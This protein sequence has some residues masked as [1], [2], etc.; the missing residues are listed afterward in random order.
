MWKRFVLNCLCD[1]SKIL[2]AENCFRLY[3]PWNR[4]NVFLLRSSADMR[5]K[6]LWVLR[7]RQN[8]RCPCRVVNFIVCIDVDR[9]PTK[10]STWSHFVHCICDPS[11][12]SHRVLW[13]KLPEICWWDLMQHSWKH[14][15]DLDRLEVC[16]TTLQ[17]W[18]MKDNLLLNLDKSEVYYFDMMQKLSRISLPSSVNVAGVRQVEEAQWYPRRWFNFGTAC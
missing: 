12:S 15:I 5:C 14:N 10:I 4:K 16:T 6:V 7:H 2:L 3:E 9:C 1:S 8:I 17:L 11:W 18:F 13:N